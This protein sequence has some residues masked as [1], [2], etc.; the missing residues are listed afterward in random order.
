MPVTHNVAT[1]TALA[2]AVAAL[3]GAGST[4][5]LYS[6]A[7]TADSAAAGTLIATIT[8]PASPWGTASAGSIAADVVWTGTGAAG[9]PAPTTVVGFRL[10]SADGTRV[11]V[12]DVGLTGSGADLTMDN[13][14]VAAGQAVEITAATIL[15]RASGG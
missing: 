11:T 10:S 6:A 4:L 3:Y 12:G 8:L 15:G 14:S 13:T 9:L 7:Q 5:R 1:R 2:D